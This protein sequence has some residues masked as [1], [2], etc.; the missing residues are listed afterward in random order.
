[1]KI[2]ETEV[3]NRYPSLVQKKL[4]D[5]I[6]FVHAEE[7]EQ[8]YPS[9]TPAEREACYAKTHG[10]IFIIGIGYPLPISGKSHGI[11]NPDADDWCSPNGNKDFHGLNGDIIFWDPALSATLEISSMGIRVGPEQ[12]E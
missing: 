9:L 7:L 10:V 1:M 2:V 8:L 6:T 5:A 12:L 11:R 3:A 4:P